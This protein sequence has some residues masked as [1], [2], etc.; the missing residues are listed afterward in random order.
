[1]IYFLSKQLLYLNFKLENNLKKLYRQ[2]HD[3]PRSL[4]VFLNSVKY[5]CQN[6]IK[7]NFVYLTRKK[8][9]VN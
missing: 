6:N 1:M 5:Y 8:F 4:L 2:N 7:E 3:S 9:P